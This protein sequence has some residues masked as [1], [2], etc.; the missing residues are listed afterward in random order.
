[1]PIL[2]ELLR[3]ELPAFPGANST[4][5]SPDRGLLAVAGVMVALLAL[6]GAVVATGAGRAVR[7]T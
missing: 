6:C 4:S 3:F 2:A 5:A 7:R 1:M